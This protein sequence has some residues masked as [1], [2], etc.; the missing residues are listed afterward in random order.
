MDHQTSA[1]PKSETEAPSID[2]VL[3][4]VATEKDLNAIA[5]DPGAI[6][7]LGFTG[8]V[9]PKSLLTTATS[10]GIRECGLMI[11]QEPSDVDLGDSID[12]SVWTSDAPPSA[13]KIWDALE[14]SPD[15][16]PGVDLTNDDLSTRRRNEVVT[17][18]QMAAPPIPVAQ[19]SAPLLYSASHREQRELLRSLIFWRKRFGIARHPSNLVHAGDDGL[20]IFTIDSWLIA[21]N[22]NQDEVS[23]DLGSRGSMWLMLGTQREVH[24]HGA[25]LV[26]PGYS[27]AIMANEL[28]R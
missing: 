25:L 5:T 10:I 16:S 24:L 15:Y 21:L 17:A 14:K 11:H 8:I 22:Q 18:L 2:A 27:G 19:I 26:L 12:L 1:S 13:E 20:L 9:A 23:I 7:K 6:E 3:C 4:R 28:A